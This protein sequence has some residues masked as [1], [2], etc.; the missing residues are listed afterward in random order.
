MNRDW[1]CFGT[2]FLVA[3]GLALHAA[4]VTSLK[5]LS[6]NIKVNA[7]LGLN[8][9]EQAIKNENPDVVLLQEADGYTI[10]PIA[11]SLGGFYWI[12]TG[13]AGQYG[14]VSR[15]PIIKRIGETTEPYGGVGATIELSPNQRVHVFSAHLNYTPYGPYELVAGTSINKVISDENAARMPGL[16]ELLGMAGPFIAGAEPVLLTGDFNAPSDLDYSP[17]VAWPESVACRNAGLVDSYAAVNPITKKFAGLFA[18]DDPG[19]TWT[20]LTQYEPNHCFDRIDFIYYSGGDGMTTTASTDVDSRNDNVNPWPSDHR[21]LLSTFS[22]ALP[23]SQTQPS[24]PVPANAGTSAPL[25]PAMTWIPG[26]NAT[27]HNIYFGTT[28]P[29]N[30]V[31]N[32]VT[33]SLFKP[34]RLSPNTTYYWH[35]DEVTAGGNV[36][37]AVWSFKTGNFSWADPSK[38]AYVRNENVT[39]NFG[40]APGNTTDWVGIY[41]AG[42]AYGPGNVP[43]IKWSYLNGSQAAPR[44][45]IKSGTLTFTGLPAGSYVARFFSNDGF[46]LLDEAAFTVGP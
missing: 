8:A 36:T 24:S 22:L 35:V 7:S 14:I 28:S 10:Q 21:A 5:V 45:A 20:P 40:N 18:F 6:F 33:D 16:N 46:F 30:F 23:A 17:A 2:L 15:Y 32:L 25:R 4:P 9:V 3:G 41:A 37:G 1:K 12:Q 13:G 44:R 11:S 29:G 26:K 19:I 43:S 38:P 31:T 27:S 42:T 34:G 39:I